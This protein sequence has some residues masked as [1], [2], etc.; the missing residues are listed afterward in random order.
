MKVPFV[1]LK[2]QY[3]SIKEDIDNAIQNVIEQS[4][5]IGGSA[6]KQF[7]AAF[8]SYVGVR[9]CIAC[10]NG[11]DSIEILLKAMNIGAGDEVIVPANSWIST[12]EAVSAIGA[13]PVFVDVDDFYSINIQ[14][15]EKKITGKT[16]A[17]IPVHLY[18]HPADMPAV[19]QL[20]E[21]YNLKVIEDCAQ[22]HGAEINGKR[23]GTWGHA[24]SFSFYPGKNLGAYG[25]AGAM[26]TNDDELAAVSR[27]IP[28]HGQIKKHHHVREGRNSRM[29][30]IQAAILLAKL[31]HLEQW[32]KQRIR[33]ATLYNELLQEANVIIPLTNKN[34]SHVFHLYVIRTENREELQAYLSEKGIETAVHYPTA[35]PLLPCYSRYNYASKDFPVSYYNQS[36]ILSLPMFAELSDEQIEY[37]AILIKSFYK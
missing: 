27:Q 22:S 2:K 20:A 7:E 30:T 4:A 37:V 33:H 10:G 18:G 8:A 13:T 16:K 6:I 26:L 32:T 5:Y 24:A 15:A 17:I 14:L 35:L 3:L 25:D 29:D 21:K 19:I 28:N 11:T 9:H 1:D 31:P 12:S 36:R 34:C 23:T